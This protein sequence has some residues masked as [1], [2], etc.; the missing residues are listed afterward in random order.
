MTNDENLKGQFVF[1]VGAD[2][3]EQPKPWGCFFC[4]ADRADGCT[5]VS[6]SGN[7]FHV[8]RAFVRRHRE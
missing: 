4:V 8:D 5:L 2:N 7:A 3:C 6:S 1:L